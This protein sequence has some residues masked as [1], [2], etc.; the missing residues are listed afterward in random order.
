MEIR[1]MSF[2]TPQ[3][4]FNSFG[5][6]GSFPGYT[7]P[8]NAQFPFPGNHSNAWNTN[9]GWNNQFGGWGNQFPGF[10]PTTSNWNNTSPW[11][12]FFG[13]S[14]FSNQF[15]ESF[16]WGFG[17]NQ[18][19]PWNNQSWNSQPWNHAFPFS[20]QQS[21][22]NSFSPWNTPFAGNQASPFGWNQA[23]P[24]ASSPFASFPFGWWNQ[25]QQ[26][27][28]GTTNEQSG[29]SPAAQSGY[30]FPFAGFNPFFCF[31]PQTAPTSNGATQAA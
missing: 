12:N 23:S 9:P 20:G 7:Q 15:N 30:P 26:Q 11:S 4:G 1:N 22:F 27:T 24:F 14:N 17:Q 19:Q 28:P 13:G 25:A 29:A 10:S 31:N 8:W 21:S 16:P 3:F 6:G 18:S 5:G 2:F